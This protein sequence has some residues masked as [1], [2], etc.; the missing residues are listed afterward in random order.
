V[1]AVASLVGSR[2]DRQRNLFLGLVFLL[3]ALFGG[4]IVGANLTLSAWETGLI[5]LAL[6]CCAL[7]FLIRGIRGSGARGQPQVPDPAGGS[8]RRYLIAGAALAV[9]AFVTLLVGQTR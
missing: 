9:V 6:G 8:R 5:Q 1:D 7:L 3:G 4:R 2:I